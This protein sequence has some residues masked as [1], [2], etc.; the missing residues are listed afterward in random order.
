MGSQTAVWFSTDWRKRKLLRICSV[1]SRSTSKGKPLRF[2]YMVSTI[3][4][5]I[6]RAQRSFKERGTMKDHLRK[7]LNGHKRFP[8][9]KAHRVGWSKRRAMLEVHPRDLPEMTS[10]ISW[11]HTRDDNFRT[12]G[13]MRQGVQSNE[14]QGR[15]T[16]NSSANFFRI[17]WWKECLVRVK[18]RLAQQ[19]CSESTSSCGHWTH[20][21]QTWQLPNSNWKEGEYGRLSP[22]TQRNT[23]HGTSCPHRNRM[24]LQRFKGTCNQDFSAQH[25]T[26]GPEFASPTT[27][28][29]SMMK[30]TWSR[31]EEW[32]MGLTKL[33]LGS[34]CTNQP[35][36][37]ELLTGR[38]RCRRV[39]RI[40]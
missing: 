38:H 8:S 13:T 15:E 6:V 37:M 27:H 1:I 34:G 7:R 18:A 25:T 12:K 29:A 21:W 4:Q 40:L 11:E 36:R 2:A 33:Q 30:R 19:V 31:E 17:Q 10:P 39:S 5:F 3:A 14:S 22:W 35:R 28:L 16:P 32:I 20:G 23:I 9:H 24:E 26:D